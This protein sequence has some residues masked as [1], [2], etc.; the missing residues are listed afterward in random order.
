MNEANS[1]QVGQLTTAPLGVLIP[2]K[3]GN[4]RKKKRTRE[5]IHRMAVSI[6]MHGGVLQN[7]VVVP[8]EHDGKQTGRLE[9]VAGETR[10]LALCA[11]RDGWI[12]DAKGY[13]DDF[14]V[15]ILVR[16]RDEATAASTTENIEREDMH[17]ADQFLAFQKMVDDCGSIEEVA[18]MYGVAPVV[19]KRRRKLAN[20]APKLL[21][22]YRQDGTTLDQLIA[23]CI[24]D[25]HEAQL[26]VWEA[27][28][29]RE[30]DRSPDRLRQAMTAGEIE[31][32]SPLAR[33]VGL[34]AT[35]MRAGRC[36][37][38]CSATRTRA[39]SSMC[40]CCTASP[41]SAW[42]PAPRKSGPRA[43]AG[44]RRASRCSTTS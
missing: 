3:D 15:P 33:L 12:E 16:A 10:R 19:V 30:W 41:S 11:L 29:G 8:E 39:T 26:K 21:K 34:K 42:K 31:L 1:Y 2:A 27:T 9:V 38:T 40:Y 24:S 22:L 18:A 4:A 32:D 37:A 43:G 35:K 7:L 25:D 44:S 23:L 36:A 6:H 5:R 14:A 28:K 20:A 17:P 13:T